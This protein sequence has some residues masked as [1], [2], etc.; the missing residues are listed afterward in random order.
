[1]PTGSR[2]MSNN[3]IT[4][5]HRRLE[6]VGVSCS[7]SLS[8]N[9]RQWEPAPD[10]GLATLSDPRLSSPAEWERS[11]AIVRGTWGQYVVVCSVSNSPL[12]HNPFRNPFK[13]KV[14]EVYF[15]K[16]VCL[17]VIIVD[18]VS[19]YICICIVVSRLYNTHGCSQ[20]SCLLTDRTPL[21]SPNH[22]N[23]QLSNFIS[24][25]C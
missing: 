10:R 18:Y 5:C 23:M 13:N 9:S 14:R 1:M 21:N 3:Y 12:I 8:C 22:I 16:E 25:T 24:Y 15:S 11:A 2:C 17:F 4:R 7:W 6:L 20:L 19:A